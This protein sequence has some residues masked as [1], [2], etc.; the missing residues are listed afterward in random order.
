VWLCSYIFSFHYE[1]DWYVF[2][3]LKVFFFLLQIILHPLTQFLNIIKL[4]S[5]S[6]DGI[7]CTAHIIC[8]FLLS[9]WQTI[10]YTQYT[11]ITNSVYTVFVISYSADGIQCTAHIICYFLLSRW[12]TILYTQYTEITN[13]VYTVFVISYSADGRQFMAHIICCFLLS[14]LQG[15]QCAVHIICYFSLSRWQGINCAAHIICYFLLGRWQT[16][17]RIYST[18]YFYGW[19]SIRMEGNDLIVI[20]GCKRMC[21]VCTKGCSL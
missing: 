9:I 19:S 4:I 11:E 21:L 20:S 7:Q 14:R 2:C 12:Q 3:R 16:I 10:L 13:T 1:T 15:I 8:Y 5:Y 6:A 18:Q 17:H